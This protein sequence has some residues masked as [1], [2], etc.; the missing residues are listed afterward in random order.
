MSE[1]TRE[2]P[3]DIGIG[4]HHL[5]GRDDQVSLI[6]SPGRCHLPA[7]LRTWGWAAQLYATRSRSSWGIGDLGDLRT[8]NRWACSQ[9]AGM[10][11]VNPLH[12]SLTGLPQESSPYSP[13][14]RCWRN[15]LYLRVEDVPGATAVEGFAAAQT[16]GRALNHSRHIDRD[17]V[18]RLKMGVLEEV[19]SAFRPDDA[20]TRFLEEGGEALFGYATFCALSEVHG[21]PWHGW[22]AELRAPGSR[23][24]GEFVAAHRSRVLFH[25]WLQWL[26]DAQLE[27]SSGDVGVVQDLAVGV[28]PDGADAWWW[29][30]CFVSTARVGAPP[31]EFNT[32][33]QDWSLPPF[34]PWRLRAVGYEPFIRMVRHGLRHA[35][36]LRI[37]H[38]MG[39]FR[40]F[41]V[42]IDGGGPADGGYVRY[43]AEDLLRI[44]ALESVR[45]GAYVVGEDL[46]VVTDEARAALRDAGVLSY[47]LV[48]FEDDP[49]SAFP[50]HALAAV[51]THDL[52]TVT[53]LFSGADLVRQRDLDMVP[54]DEGTAAMT[55]RVATRA[56]IDGDDGTEA[57]VTKVHALLATAPS[58]ILTATIEDA[59]A[60]PLRPN[61]PGVINADNWSTALSKPLEE[62]MTDPLPNEIAT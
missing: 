53:G 18:W 33:G 55:E 36:G 10:T 41:W 20:F 24:V 45:A 8:L 60:E 21:R 27:G 38:V 12:A 49:P 44:L 4:Y 9:G 59:V 35:A 2:L 19:W 57:I 6:V 43:P 48:W 30:G 23:R 52:P 47:R 56:E 29:Q 16:A 37:D 32:Q 3:R 14:S 17:E 34:D 5:R 42:P 1:H 31:D 28:H 11:L 22:P 40:L 7:N 39:L 51:T 54:N 15:P 13:S 46:G 50:H 61:Y 58:M 25:A 26:I 62:I